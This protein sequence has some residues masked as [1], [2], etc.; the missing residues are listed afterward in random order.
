[1][2][3]GWFQFRFQFRFRCCLVL[4][5]CEECESN[6]SLCKHRSS[7]IANRFVQ[8]WDIPLWNFHHLLALGCA[9]ETST[10]GAWATIYVLLIS[11]SQIDP[12]KN[13][14]AMRARR[15]A[16][17][18]FSFLRVKNRTTRNTTG[19]SGQQIWR[20]S[21]QVNTSCLTVSV[22]IH[23]TGSPMNEGDF[24]APPIPI[25]PLS[26]GTADIWH[27]VVLQLLCYSPMW[28]PAVRRRIIPQMAI[29]CS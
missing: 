6:F 27:Q 7:T 8:L 20:S 23:E 16:S 5:N 11:F 9:T 18:D 14:P 15:R 28:W 1:M 21:R 10:G 26:H 12:I 4:W 25:P 19:G 17:Q 24:M 29:E 22:R 3:R 13:F 2:D